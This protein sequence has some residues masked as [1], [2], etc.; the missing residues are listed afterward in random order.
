MYDLIGRPFRLGADGTDSDGAVD[1]I[2]LVYIALERLGIP[3]PTFDP[4]WYTAPRRTVVQALREWGNRTRKPEYNGDVV[5]L[6]HRN[7]AFGVTWQNG[8]LYTAAY[9]K[10]VT[11]APLSALPRTHCYRSACFPTNTI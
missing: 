5:L 8:I 2:H 6:P 11:W 4:D 1:C 3:C 9:I 7:Y 10:M